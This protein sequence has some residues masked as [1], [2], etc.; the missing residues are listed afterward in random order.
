MNLPPAFSKPPLRLQRLVKEAVQREGSIH[1]LWEVIRSDNEAAETHC[2]IT[3]SMLTD[4]L[5]NPETVGLTWSALVALDTYLK[6]HGASLQHLSILEQRG[7][8]EALAH[9]R[10]LFYM[11]GAKP[12]PKE[13][14]TDISH[15]DSKAQSEVQAQAAQHG[16]NYPFGTHNVIWG[17]PE[18]QSGLNSEEWC[19]I[20]REDQASVI[21]FG[22]SLAALSS[23]IMMAQM[24][25]LKPFERPVHSGRAEFPFYFV[26]LSKLAE[27][28]KSTF[29]LTW[30]ELEA[31]DPGLAAR[32]KENR[33]T[34]FILDNEV[35][36]APVESGAWNMF[37]IIAAQR[38]AAGNIW[39]VV[40]GHAGPATYGAATMVRQIAEELPW[41]VN[42]PS[43]VL[44]VPVKVHVRARKP[45][46]ADGDVR[47]V[48]GAEFVGNPR[49]WPVK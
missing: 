9:P 1:H 2:T 20:L 27:S 46:P 15:W 5:R 16:A 21:S 17:D 49:F 4:I 43:K 48:V 24:F 23:E 25:G 19:R 13:R 34:A 29:G 39:M 45:G 37:A 30:R 3:R 32:V 47:E 28:F 8:L 42:Q 26:W 31:R 40:A 14:R 44:W 38:R 18:D 35:H 41:A 22:S 7:V 33:A 6:K 11:L 36:E 12:R 10:P